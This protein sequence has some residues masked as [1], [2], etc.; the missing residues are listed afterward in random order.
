MF[1]YKLILLCQLSLLFNTY[2]LSSKYL[3]I[4]IYIR[5]FFI[6]Q[7]IYI[8]VIMIFIIKTYMYILLCYCVTV[9][10]FVSGHPDVCKPFGFMQFSQNRGH[11]AHDAING[12]CSTSCG[13]WCGSHVFFCILYNIMGSAFWVI[14]MISIQKY[15]FIYSNWFAFPRPALSR[16]YLSCMSYEVVFAVSDL[17][18]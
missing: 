8:H 17:K 2:F 5:Q 1:V 11:K 18:A 10:K 4:Y 6:I 7:Y 15:F 13:W 14:S 3:N 9:W 12:H 16:S